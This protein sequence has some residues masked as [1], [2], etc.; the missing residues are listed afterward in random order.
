VL[1]PADAAVMAL[2][3][4]GTASFSEGITPAGLDNLSVPL[5]SALALILLYQLG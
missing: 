5:A 2:F 3:A 1:G 4:A